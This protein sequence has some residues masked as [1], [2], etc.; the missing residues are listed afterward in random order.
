MGPETDL[1]G[2]PVG[3]S[4]EEQLE[5]ARGKLANAL[6]A[7]WIQRQPVRP[8]ERDIKKQSRKASQVCDGRDPRHVMLAALGMG[9]LF[10]Y[11]EGTDWDLFDLDRKFTKAVNK[12]KEHPELQRK[13]RGGIAKIRE[14][15]RG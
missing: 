12:A 7:K 13:S 15:R 14:R 4:E 6:V 8:S 11:S 10:P 3:P 1:F 5:E 9:L 2:E